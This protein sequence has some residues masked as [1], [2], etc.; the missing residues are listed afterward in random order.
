M[1]FEVWDFETGNSIAA[2]ETEAA[3]LA[4]VRDL[5][6]VDRPTYAR[7][8]ALVRGSLGDP[9]AE[10]IDEGATLAARAEAAAPGPRYVS[11]S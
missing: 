6:A 4:L 1:R 5:L 10:V 3:A 2:Y 8:L 11:G 7:T 9:D